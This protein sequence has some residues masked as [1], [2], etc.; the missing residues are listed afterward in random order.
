MRFNGGKIVIL[1]VCPSL[2][3]IYGALLSAVH[4]KIKGG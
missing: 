2:N 4:T 3:K 1:T